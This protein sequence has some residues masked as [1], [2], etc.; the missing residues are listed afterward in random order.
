MLTREY[1]YLLGEKGGP[2]YSR[3]VARSG[4]DVICTHGAPFLTLT[5]PMWDYDQRI[6]DMDAAR[7]DMAIVSLTCPNA[8]FGDAQD[9]MQAARGVN[10]SM[11]EQQI[12]RPDRISWLASLPWQY[13]LLALQELDR[14][15]RSG[16][17][18][19]MVIANISGE[20]LTEPK[21]A[22][23]WREIDKRGLPVLIHPGTPQGAR[24]MQL[25]KYGL[26]PSVGFPMDTSLSITRMILDGFFDRYQNLNIIAAHGGGALPYLAGRL[27]FCHENMSAAKEQ[28]SEKP[29]SYLRRIYYDAVVYESSALDLCIE[30]AGSADRVLFGSD[31]PHPIGDMKGCLERVDALPSLTARRIR[32]ANAVKLF[33]L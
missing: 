19:V 18:G 21:F 33:N 23:I 1:L 32:G 22:K 10:D 12:I 7:V 8:Y 30:V 29:S 2:V 16:A 13:E 9:S 20:S 3:D 6:A 31:Y 14:C 11:A 25:D 5:P 17:V 15:L 24:E 27:D 28:I 4:E 26:V